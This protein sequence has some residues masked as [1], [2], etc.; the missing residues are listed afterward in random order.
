MC[1]EVNHSFHGLY[2]VSSDGGFWLPRAFADEL[3]ASGPAGFEEAPLTPAE[4]IADVARVVERL[5][6]DHR[7]KAALNQALADLAPDA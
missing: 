2:R 5:P 3:I 4:I 6:D 1:D 7:W